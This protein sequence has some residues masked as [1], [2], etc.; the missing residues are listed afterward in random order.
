VLDHG[1]DL[2][3]FAHVA[4]VVPCAAAVLR[5]RLQLC[6]RALQHGLATATN[7]YGCALA[8]KLAGKF[9]AKAGASTSDQDPFAGQRIRAKAGGRHRG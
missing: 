8:Y 4:Q 1:F 6:H 5:Y 3:G 7:E 2:V 9:L